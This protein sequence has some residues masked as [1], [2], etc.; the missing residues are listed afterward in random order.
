MQNY[1]ELYNNLT[2]LWNSDDRNETGILLRLVEISNFRY[3]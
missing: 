2:I 3:V 1:I